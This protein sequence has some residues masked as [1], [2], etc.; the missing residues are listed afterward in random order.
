MSTQTVRSAKLRVETAAPPPELVASN[1]I[2]VG[3]V[4]PTELEA[5]PPREW[6]K[7]RTISIAINGAPVDAGPL[8]AM[9]GGAVASTDRLRSDLD[10][11]G[12]I[13]KPGDIVLA[14]TPLSLHLVRAGDHLA[15]FVDDR[16]YVHCRFA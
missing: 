6:A 4:V 5:T 2:N 16:E 12:E 11:F 10:R 1:G 13:L 7:A 8:W 15:I 9:P 3:M 14:G